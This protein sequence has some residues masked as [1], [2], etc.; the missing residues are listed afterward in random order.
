MSQALFN[1]IEGKVIPSGKLPVT[2]PNI[3]NEQQ[4]D[5][6]QYP[7]VNDVSHYTE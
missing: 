6:D 5:P 7:G 2:L 1:I 3:D 4:M